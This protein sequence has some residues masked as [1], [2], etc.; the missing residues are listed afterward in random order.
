MGGV[1]TNGGLCDKFAL[2]AQLLDERLRLSHSQSNGAR[3]GE[4]DVQE[5]H[6]ENKEDVQVC[7]LE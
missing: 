6:R 5:V 2:S 3:R 1:L 4:K 7:A